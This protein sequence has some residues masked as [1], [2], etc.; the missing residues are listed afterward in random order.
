MEK[1]LSPDFF[2]NRKEQ[3]QIEEAIILAIKPG[4]Y[5]HNIVI[6]LANMLRHYTQEMVKDEVLGDASGEMYEGGDG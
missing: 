4:M 6:A 1:P 2:A 3:L 5:Y